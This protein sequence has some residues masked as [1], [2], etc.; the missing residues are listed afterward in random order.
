MKKK[1]G[2]HFRASSWAVGIVLLL[3]MSAVASADSDGWSDPNDAR[4]GID[5][6]TYTQGHNA[7]GKLIHKVVAFEAFSNRD[8]RE[9]CLY[10]DTFNESGGAAG[11]YQLCGNGKITNLDSGVISDA[12]VK[13][14]NGKTIKLIFGEGAIGQPASYKWQIATVSQDCTRGAQSG[15]CDLAPNSGKRNHDI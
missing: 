9:L 5:V 7:A 11:S 13:R 15:L 8:A 3:S 10:I 6:D 4:D 12:N 14:P 1:N 2:N